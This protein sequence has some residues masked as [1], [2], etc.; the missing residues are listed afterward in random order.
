MDSLLNVMNAIRLSYCDI[1]AA[2]GMDLV[3]RV[4]NH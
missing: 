4:S 3:K 2:L 1:L